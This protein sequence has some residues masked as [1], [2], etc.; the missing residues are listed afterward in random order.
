[1][2]EKKKTKKSDKKIYVTLVLLCSLVCWEDI[3]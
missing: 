3:L 1:M 2:S